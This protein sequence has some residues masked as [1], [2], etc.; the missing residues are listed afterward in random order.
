MTEKG[1]N[2]GSGRPVL[3]SMVDGNVARRREL[4]AISVR[5]RQATAGKGG[6]SRLGECMTSPSDPTDA[7]PCKDLLTKVPRPTSALMIFRCSKRKKADVTVV[8]LT[9]RVRESSR[10]VGRRSP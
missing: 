8:A 10:T 3:Q 9:L 1:S 7:S 2:A 4:N 5:R 6:L